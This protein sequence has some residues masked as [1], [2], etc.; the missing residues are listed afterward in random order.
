MKI[1]VMGAGGVGGYLGARLAHAGQHVHFV[2]RGAHLAAMHGA[3]L[4]GDPIFDEQDGV[5][6][7]NVAGQS[8]TFQLLTRSEAWAPD[9]AVGH[10][11][12]NAIAAPFHALV[13]E[14]PIRPGDVVAAGDAIVVIEAMKM[15]HT[16]AAAG[17]GTVD[18]VRVA[19]VGSVEM[20]TTAV[21]FVARPDHIRNPS[22]DANHRQAD[23]DSHHRQPAQLTGV[24][25]VDQRRDPGG[26]ARVR[27]RW[28]RRTPRGS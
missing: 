22:P 19:V 27:L 10:G 6:V 25:E 13:T 4:R 18:E 3:G 5:V 8:H 2:A 1:A 15:L 17:P 11:S 7:V 24:E 12:A 28:P 9:E 23:D 20:R 26:R 16:L 21:L 14:V